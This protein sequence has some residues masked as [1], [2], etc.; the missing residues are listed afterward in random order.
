MPDTVIILTI[1]SCANK[2]N[3]VRVISRA[4]KVSLMHIGSS[5]TKDNN[6]QIST[7][8]AEASLVHLNLTRDEQRKYL[9]WF[10]MFRNS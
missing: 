9:E 10:Y 4:T 8:A 3:R 7:C 2:V 6:V 1:I 5:V